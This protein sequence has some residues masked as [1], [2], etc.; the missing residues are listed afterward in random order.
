MYP[1]IEPYKTHYLPTGEGHVLYVEECGNPNGIPVV[2]LH[3]GPGGHCKPYQ[4][5]LFNPELYR[6]ILFD[7][8]GAGRS[9]P[10][11]SLQTNTTQEL[12]KDIEKL[13][14]KL[15]IEQWLI[16]GGSWGSALGL[17]Y[18][19][20]FPDRVLAMILRGIFLAR[21]KDVRWL[22]SEEGVGRLFPAQWQLLMS[23][24]PIE[25][26]ENPLPLYY[27]LLTHQDDDIAQMAA[28][29]LVGWS[30][31]IVSHNTFPTPVECTEEMLSEVRIECHYAANQFFIEDNQV[32]QRMNK[33]Q[34]IS[35]IIIHGQQD[36]LCPLEGAYTLH[37]AWEN[38][39]LRILPTGGHLTNEPET[40]DAIVQATDE[41]S[42]MLAEQFF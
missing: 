33:L 27:D 21:Q 25:S 28:L 14:R 36:L 35:S 37:Q 17:L 10:K 24:I 19:Q 6:I 42:E 23:L 7:Q 26:R 38:S 32:I 29:N 18:A 30:G 41:M 39:E 9:I 12:I 2:F 1:E 40:L 20:Y 4:R 34:N 3:G 13:R 22:Y 31:C 8:R 15:N 16:F 5:S 11:G